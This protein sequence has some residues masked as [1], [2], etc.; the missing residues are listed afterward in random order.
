MN[1]QFLRQTRRGAR[2]DWAWFAAAFVLLQVLFVAA[3]EKRRPEVYDPEYG[4]RLRLLKRQQRD[5][6]G[7]PLLVSLGSSRLGCGLIPEQLPPL[8]GGAQDKTVPFNFTHL[9]GGPTWNRLSLDRLLRA[10]IRPSWLVVEFLPLALCGEGPG[11]LSNSASADLP[12][13][14]RY[15]G[16]R[17]GGIYLRSRLNPFYNF[18]QGVLRK[19]APEWV[20][21]V[22]TSD[23][24]ALG[25]LGGDHGWFHHEED[26][27]TESERAR[28]L[29][30][31]KRGDYGRLQDWQVNPRSDQAMRETLQQC[32]DLRIPTALVYMPVSQTYQSWIS[33]KTRGKMQDYLEEL[34]ATFGV[35]LIDAHAWISDDALYTDG[36]HLTQAGAAEFTARFGQEALL[37]WLTEKTEVAQR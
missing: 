13:L 17:A 31:T 24:I 16:V 37:P 14:M 27:L 8:P 20:T 11:L 33:A 1:T 23:T 18:R 30:F 2:K 32:R 25:P 35:R 3:I 22:A 12:V 26:K 21:S 5:H 34:R 9:A 6:P 36:H 10:D 28:R 15:A 4:V 29:D 7:Q 19:C